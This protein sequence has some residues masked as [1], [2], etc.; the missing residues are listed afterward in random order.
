MTRRERSDDVTD[1]GRGTER[2]GT[3]RQRRRRQ[4]ATTREQLLVAAR[5]TFEARGYQA[6]TVTAVTSTADTAHGTFYL[7]F[8]NKEDAFGNVIEDIAEQLYR[9]A[10]GRS[11]PGSPYDAIEQATRGFLQVFVDHQGLW[12][13]LLEAIMQSE[14]VEQMWLGVRRRFI[15]RIARTLAR[16]LDEG[17]IEALD[18]DLAAHA[19]ASMAEWFAF[20][21]FV[22]EEPAVT[23]ESFEAA[24]RALSD[25]WYRAMYGR[26]LADLDTPRSSAG[27]SSPI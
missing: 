12:R 10:S 21:H 15:G 11:D 24:V 22:L 2:E 6:T 25:L 8:K 19:L 5:E 18:P 9:E 26:V 17:A 13:A 20:T 3:A 4:P 27:A 14:A 23:D 1:G 7:Y 16:L